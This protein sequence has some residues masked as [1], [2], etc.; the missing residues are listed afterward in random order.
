M[1]KIS[2]K[3]SAHS[4]RGAKRKLNQDSLGIKDWRNQ[5]EFSDSFNINLAAFD[6]PALLLLADGIGGHDEGEIASKTAIDKIFQSF[7]YKAEDYNIP[8]AIIEAHSTLNLFSPLSYRPMGTTILGIVLNPFGATLFN[9]GDSRGYKLSNGKLDK[10]TTDDVANSAQTN[11]ITQ[12]LGGGTKVPKPHYSKQHYSPGDSFIL[13]SDGITDWLLEDDIYKIVKT[14]GSESAVELCHQA[15]KAGS[16]D[17]VSA[18][19]ILC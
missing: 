12:C 9:V 10:L 2:F 3:V 13:M 17:D 5:K 14:C 18:V 8:S 7:D 11:V 19:V 4:Q 1:E 16:G 15:V 6:L